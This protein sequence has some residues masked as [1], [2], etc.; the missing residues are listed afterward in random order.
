MEHLRSE[1]YNFAMLRSSPLA[2]RK[3]TILHLESQPTWHL[4]NLHRDWERCIALR[5]CFMLCVSFVPFVQNCS[6]LVFQRLCTNI[7]LEPLVLFH[8]CVHPWPPGAPCW[9]QK[10]L[11]QFSEQRFRLLRIFL[12]SWA[13]RN[14]WFQLFVLPLTTHSNSKGT[15]VAWNQKPPLSVIKLLFRL[16]AIRMF[17]LVF[18]NKIFQAGNASRWRPCQLQAK[19]L[20]RDN[21]WQTEHTTAS[22]FID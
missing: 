6:V 2:H 3:K 1:T 19:Q 21:H 18:S 10:Q 17:S 8:L 5:H 9:E 13:A 14:T 20:R 16:F 4:N 11:S 15:Q 7:C 12:P 22:F